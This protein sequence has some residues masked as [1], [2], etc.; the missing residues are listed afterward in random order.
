MG[1]WWPK[2][3]ARKYMQ[4]LTEIGKTM[5]LPPFLDGLDVSKIP[6]T[7][8]SLPDQR[9]EI[10]EIVYSNA[11]LLRS[12]LEGK[13]GLVEDETAAL[14]DFMQAKLRSALFERPEKERAIQDA[15]EQL[16]IGR[17]LQKGEDYDREVGRVK[18]SSKES[19]P[20]FIFQRLGIG[21]EVKLVNAAA[22]AK[23]VIDEINADIAAYSKGYRTLMF[24]VYD[25]GFIRDEMEFRNDLERTG[26]VSIIVVKH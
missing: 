15:L 14:R 20:D 21:L 9:K 18:F 10:F 23:E 2:V 19:V 8:D 22:R 26:N 6:G 13:L 24:V 11:A 1:A 3:F 16:L 5:Q 4:I 12:F 25:T 7:G 17:G